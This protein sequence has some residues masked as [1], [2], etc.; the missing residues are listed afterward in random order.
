MFEGVELYVCYGTFGT[1]ERHPCKK[2]HKALSDAGYEPRVV[3]TGGCYG[4]DPLWSGRRA[5][6]RLTGNYKVP[7]LFLDGG[8][9]IDGTTNIVAWAESNPASGS[10]RPGSAPR[11]R[12]AQAP[13]PAG[14]G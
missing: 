3:R 9:I 14:P 8:T 6:K 10:E 4:T 5:I 1:P 13:G 7:T 2:A 12:T 11:A